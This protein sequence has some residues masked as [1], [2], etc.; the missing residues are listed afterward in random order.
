MLERPR[1]RWSIA[2]RTVRS[3][4]IVFSSPSFDEHLRFPERVEDLA[5]QKLVTELAVERLDVAV[6]PRTARLDVKRLHVDPSQPLPNL[7]RGELGAVVGT[8]VSRH[9]AADEQV[10]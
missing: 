2:E 3:D 8:D 10:A 6:L 9:A 7:R 4:R 5:I 1:E